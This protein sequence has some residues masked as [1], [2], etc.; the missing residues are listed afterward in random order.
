MGDGVWAAVMGR[1]VRAGGDRGE[2]TFSAHHPREDAGNFQDLD[3]ATTF[4]HVLKT[5]PHHTK[6]SG[7]RDTELS[8]PKINS[9]LWFTD[10]GNLRVVSG[11]LSLHREAVFSL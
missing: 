6:N 8:R 1:L 7:F 2:V 3:S 10:G 9:V 11:I 5:V 4:P